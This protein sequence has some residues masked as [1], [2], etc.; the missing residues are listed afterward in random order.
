MR[1]ALFENAVVSNALKERLHSGESAELY[2]WRDNNGVE[3]D[4]LFETPQGLQT[5]EIKSGATPTTDM[6]RSGQKS[7]HF[8]AGAALTPWLVYAGEESYERSGV[9][10]MGWRGFSL[11][12]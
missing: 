10:L 4:L 2:F 9:R 6:I 7:S 5:V 1:G 12:G 3:A 8:A 11:L